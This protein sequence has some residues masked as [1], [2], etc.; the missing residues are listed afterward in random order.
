MRKNNLLMKVKD[1]MIKNVIFAT[2]DENLSNVIKKLR[3]N[4]ITGLP[5]IDES[6]K[7]KS[8]ISITDI[9]K[10]AEKYGL[11]NLALISVKDFIKRKRRLIYV[12][13]N[14]S[15]EHA[16]KLMVKKD[17]H[18][19]PVVDKSKKVIGII[20]REEILDYFY[21]LL[22]EKK[23]EVKKETISTI[24]DKILEKLEKKKEISISELEK[25]LKINKSSLENICSLLEK[26]GLI[27]MIY[28]LKDIKIRKK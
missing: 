24:I 9:M 2:L 16:I 22:L 10:Y 5:I 23:I 14:D 19:L 1:I 27:E 6:G 3:E 8:V 21:K 25:E 7:L 26:A 28:E 4:K 20:T 11:E 17:V 13:E 18:R 15:I 12:N